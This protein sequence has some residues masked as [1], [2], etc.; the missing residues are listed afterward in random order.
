VSRQQREALDEL[1][2]H[3]PLDL[4]GELTVQRPLLDQLM[5]AHPLPGDVTTSPGTLGGVPVVEVD[6]P[7]GSADMT[8]LFFHGGA[9]ALGTAAAAAGLASDI[10][11]KAGAR[12]VSVDYRLAPEDP[13]PA[14][15]EDAVAAYRGLLQTGVP[16]TRIA[17]A[18]ESAGAGLAVAM[19]VSARAAG[20][21]QPSCAVLL[22]PWVDLTLSGTSVRTKADA[23]PALTGPGLARRAADYTSDADPTD[24]L[25]SPVFADLSGLPPLLIQAGS[26]EILLDDAVR[27]TARAAGD[28]VAVTLQVTPGVP[29][30][31]QGFAAV[32][33]EGETALVHVGTFLQAHLD[34]DPS[35]PD[36]ASPDHS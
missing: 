25:I 10:A 18:G 2:R 23:D 15:L 27:I 32:L 22:S 24:G 28:D 33:D 35:R 5:T 16:P 21:P 20:L 34:A 17:V 36:H 3:G 31:F 30:V 9:Y 29:H 11:R 13:H 14:A 1:L 7:G 26:H 4:G 8:V 12:A 6:V 19:L